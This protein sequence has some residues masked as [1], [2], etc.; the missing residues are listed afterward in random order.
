MVFTP[1]LALTVLLQ[2]APV[3]PPRAAPPPRDAP[4]AKE[5]TA[6]IRGRVTAAD[7]GQ[8]LRRAFVSLMGGPSGQGGVV[9]GGI[10]TPGAPSG[11]RTVPTNADGRFE[12]SRLPAGTYRVR[13]TGGTYR[14]QYLTVAFGGKTQ[15]DAGEAIELT[16]GAQFQA[17]VALPRGGAIVGRVLDDFGEPVSRVSVFPV[18]VMPGGNFQR[19]GGGFNQT[20]DLG[21]F[22]LFGLEPGE[23]VVAAEAR[24]MG[25]PPVE[26]ASEGFVTTYFP[27]ALTDR[28]A[29]RIRVA[30]TTDSGDVE[31]MLVRTRT[32]RITG[33]V[34]DSRGTIVMHPNGMLVRPEGSG[35]GFATNGMFNVDAAGKF[36]IRDVVPG[37]Y[38]FVI[39]PMG[40]P[41][42]Q[43]QKEQPRSEYAMVPLSI[44]A[45]IEDLV[46]VTQPGTTVSGQVV[47]AEGTPQNTPTA[48]RVFTQ[49]AER[50]MVMGPQP[51]V[52]VGS[53]LQF[54]LNDL[55]GPQ[56]IRLGGLPPG[57]ALKAVMLGATDITDTPV[58]FKSE[59]S[60]Q[61]QIVVTTRASALDGTVTDDRAEPSQDVMVLAIPDEK[62][63]WK[64][65]SPR[66]RMTLVSKG[67]F[68]LRGLLAGRYHVVALP[69]SRMML[70]SDTSPEA[71]E[72]LVKEAT[73]VVVGEDD[74]RTL[75]LRVAKDSQDR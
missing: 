36:T 54:T 46:V 30:G 56:L 69:R 18:R 23:Y 26:G 17:N 32:F 75:D 61:L 66:L 8:P 62:T 73:T 15:M 14:G 38:R 65:G 6:V 42:N 43:Q 9:G 7:T 71:Y 35:G 13:V 24:P 39:R 44:T 72:A 25:G 34:M 2:T 29:S 57:Q 41:P 5:G 52:T 59:H 37:D 4:P 19:T 33:T 28:E 60:R 21:R 68:E 64:L 27:S 20:D 70:T 74:K 1:V 67:K 12:F 16:D 11:P 49:P 40:Q 63:S 58:E 3:Q 55:F 10:M 31:I 50:V 48:L 47:F 45:D 22:R 53:N 51:N